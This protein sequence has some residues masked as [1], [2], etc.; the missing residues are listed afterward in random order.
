MLLLAFK[1]KQK[2]LKKK[3]G[4]QLMQNN[5][6]LY[7]SRYTLHI[8]MSKPR[9]LNQN[10]QIKMKTIDLEYWPQFWPLMK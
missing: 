7:K 2:T 5:K 9:I 8:H 4:L 3:I 10:V 1:K 6:R